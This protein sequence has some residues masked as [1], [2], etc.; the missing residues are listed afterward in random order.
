LFL[1]RLN[2]VL[3]RRTY[4]LDSANQSLTRLSTPAASVPTKV[5]TLFCG[6]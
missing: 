1:R 2:A 4:T 6:L 5:L 3:V